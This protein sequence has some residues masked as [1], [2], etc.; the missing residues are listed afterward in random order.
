MY[1]DTYFFRSPYPK[2]HVSYCQQFASVVIVIVGKLLHFN[3][4]RNHLANIAFAYC[5][6]RRFYRSNFL[7]HKGNNSY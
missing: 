4:L 6:I 1:D 5:K 7:W 2:G 3:L